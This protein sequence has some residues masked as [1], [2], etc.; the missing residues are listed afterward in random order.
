MKQLLISS[1][2]IFSFLSPAFS[3][4]QI[5]VSGDQPGEIYFVGPTLSTT[6]WGITG[7]YYSPDYGNTIVLRDSISD[8]DLIEYGSLLKDASE[9]HIYRIFADT[10]GYSIFSLYLTSDG[11]YSWCNMDSGMI[12]YPKLASGTIPG[13]IYRTIYDGPILERSIDYGANFNPCS[14]QGLINNGYSIACGVDSG[15]VYFW[16]AGKLYYSS[17]YGENIVL[18]NDLYANFNINPSSK[19]VN[20]TLQGEVYIHYIQHLWRCYAYGDSAQDLIQWGIPWWY[21]S[22]VTATDTPGEIYLLVNETGLGFGGTV[23]IFHTTDYFANWTETIHDIDPYG[24]VN[25]RSPFPGKVELIVFPNPSNN[26]FNIRYNLDAYE[27]VRLFIYN[28][29]GQK[30]WYTDI[31]RQS[32][33]VNLYKYS[34]ENIPSGMYFLEISTEKMKESIPFTIIK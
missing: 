15:E 17:D 14:G 22:G 12:H 29:I 27:Y 5:V 20:G 6:V 7:F 2:L 11:G 4:T 21:C 34:A 31:G 10:P 18:L 8:P 9:E 13:E 23:H 32:P 19:M 28:S 25:N 16:G 1:I 3:D 24:S 26:S 33:G 30:I